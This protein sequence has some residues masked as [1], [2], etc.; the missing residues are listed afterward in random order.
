MSIQSQLKERAA[1]KLE[2]TRNN[3]TNRQLRKRLNVIEE[4][5]KE[6]IDQQEQDGVKYEDNSFMI[7]YKTSYKRKCKKE[8]EIDTIRLLNDMGIRDSKEAYNTLQKI[9]IGE[10]VEVSRLKVIKYK[11]NS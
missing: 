5:V 11:S 3:Q 6:Y 7:E 2:I 8:K 4:E 10:P 9:Q 1:I